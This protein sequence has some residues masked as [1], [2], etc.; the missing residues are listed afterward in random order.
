MKRFLQKIIEYSLYLLGVVIVIFFLI[1]DPYSRSSHEVNVRLASERLQAIDERKMMI[2]GGS[3]CQFGFNSQ[4]LHDHYGL[5]VV[6]TATHACIG[7]QLQVNLY[8]SFIRPGDVVLLIPEYEQYFSAEL[9]NGCLDESLLRILLSNYPKGLT[10]LTLAQW[11]TTIPWIPQYITKALTHRPIGPLDPYS[12]TGI[13]EYGDVTNWEYKKAVY[14]EHPETSLFPI[15]VNMEALEF[16]ANFKNYCEEQN[17]K[18]F[19]FPPTIA[20]SKALP[21]TDFCTSLEQALINN[22]TPYC[23]SPQRYFLPDSMFFDTYYHMVKIGAEC[24]T[25][26]II[27]DLDSL[28]TQQ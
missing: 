16:L 13:N 3:G 24:R 9:Y 23:V 15:Y 19:L 7:L 20:M 21:N 25:N 5:P 27:H 26:M 2:I 28:L 11:K 1:Y 6:N 14:Q 4:L 10:K 22:N 8:K 17:A 18:L 12:A